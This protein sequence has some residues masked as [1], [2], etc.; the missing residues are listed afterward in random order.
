MFMKRKTKIMLAAITSVIAVSLIPTITSAITAPVATAFAYDIYK[1]VV[2]DILQGPIGFVGG[3][4]AI[5]IG[6]AQLAKNWILAILGVVTGTVIIKADAI[7][8]SLGMMTSAI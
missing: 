6:A 5:I 3:L 8:T 7:V 4:A 2:I 1:L